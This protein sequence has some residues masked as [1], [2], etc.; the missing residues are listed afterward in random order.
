MLKNG[1]VLVC[2]LDTVSGRWSLVQRSK[3]HGLV[4]PWFVYLSS[5]ALP[6]LI[7]LCKW[8]SRYYSIMVPMNVGLASPSYATHH[9]CHTSYMVILD[10]LRI[11]SF[12]IGSHRDT[13]SLALSVA[14]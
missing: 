9:I 1:R 10:L 8:L 14:P 2:P 5:G 11:L 12:L 7:L 13:L 3:V 6:M 4:A